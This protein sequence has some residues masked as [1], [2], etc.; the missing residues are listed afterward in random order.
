[1]KMFW[2][3]ITGYCGLLTSPYLLGAGRRMRY[4]LLSK[5]RVM[6][7][8]AGEGNVSI[9]VSEQFSSNRKKQDLCYIMH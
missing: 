6:L 7:Q 5:G 4:S 1:M 3:Y 8:R 2:I 9:T